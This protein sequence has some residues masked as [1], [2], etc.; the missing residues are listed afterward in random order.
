MATKKK[1]QSHGAGTRKF[2]RNE[3]KCAR[4][5]ADH[6]RE[7]NKLRKLKKLYRIQPNNYQLVNVIKHLET[8]I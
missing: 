1:R 8:I 3:V 4:Y 5:R 6:R 2:G 7:K